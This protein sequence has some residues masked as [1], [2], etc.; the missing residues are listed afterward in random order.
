MMVILGCVVLSALIG[1]MVYIVCPLLPSLVMPPG[2]LTPFA[3]WTAG[4]VNGVMTVWAL[5]A[6]R[7]GLS[8][9]RTSAGIREPPGAR[10][11]SSGFSGSSDS[12]CSPTGTQ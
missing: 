3:V 1:V 2:R 4:I 11:R 8:Q 9:P 10:P 7:R 5:W 6:W 12:F